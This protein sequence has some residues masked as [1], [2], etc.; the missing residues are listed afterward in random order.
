VSHCFPANA[1]LSDPYVFGMEGIMKTYET[2]LKNVELSG[3]TFFAPLIKEA[4]NLAEMNKK[5]GSMEYTILLILTDGEI[6]D[7]ENTINCLISSAGLPLSIVIVGIGKADFDNMTKLDGD[8]G[9]QN[10]EGVKAQRDLVQFVPFREYQ[11]SQEMLAKAVLEEIP[12]QLVEY[13]TSMGILPR[14]VVQE[15]VDKMFGIVNPLPMM[16]SSVGGKGD[17]AVATKMNTLEMKNPDVM[18]EE[19]MDFEF[20]MTTSQPYS[21]RID[22]DARNGQYGNGQYGNGQYGNGQYGNNQ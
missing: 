22:F 14:P 12:D 2:C 18:E 15:D 19:K 21:A 3:P 7:M 13:M 9:L 10:S 16:M 5:N 8:D 1:N 20:V 11:S 4:M 17:D 6:H